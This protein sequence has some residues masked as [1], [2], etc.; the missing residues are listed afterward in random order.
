[1]STQTLEF[2]KRDIKILRDLARRVADIAALPI[3][4]QKA[5]MW[6]QHNDLNRIRPMVL[7]FPE[8]SWRELLPRS[9]LQCEGPRAQDYEYDLRVRLYYAEHLP[10]DNVIEPYIPSPIVMRRTGWGLEGQVTRPDD[11]LGAYHIDCAVQSE[12]DLERLQIPTVTVDWD[13]TES[14]YRT[15]QEVFDS[16]LIVEKQGQGN[17]GLAPLDHYAQLRGIDRMFM[18]LVENP[19]MVHRAISRI[20]DGHIALVK[21]MEQQG[22]LTLGNRRHYV[23]SG[24][25]GFTHQL[26]QAG[27]DGRVRTCDLWGFATA[28][29]FS[30]VSPTMHEEFALRHEARALE[31]F[32]LN[33]YGCCEP[34]HH[35]L[36]RIKRCIPRLR[37]VSISPWADVERSAAELADKYIFSWKPNPAIVASER[38]NP[39]AARRIIRDFLQKTR[40][41]IVEMIMKDTHTCRNKPQR[42]WDWVRIAKEEAEAFA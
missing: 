24:G 9:V 20:V 3:Q 11:P 34:L 14:L 10:D 12:A 32:G 39:Q 2:T 6:R 35:K 36:D 8:G 41:C 31:L 1:M 18:D 22:A 15:L 13:E 37:R 28:Q 25:T 7:I 27:F 33:C 26:P 23:G 29:I 30:E 42:M 40:G 38:W 19:Q 21:S 5:E 16:V 17:Y 4:Q